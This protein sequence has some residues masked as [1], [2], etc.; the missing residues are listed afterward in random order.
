MDSDQMVNTELVDTIVREVKSQG[1]FDQFRK[2]CLADVD[3]KPAYQNLRQRVESAVTTF[4]EQQEWRPDANRIQMRE[5]LRKNIIGLGFLETGVDRIVDQVVNPKISSVFMPQIEDVVYKYLGIEKPIAKPKEE[6]TFEQNG[7]KNFDL[8][9][10]D[11]LEAVSPDSSKSA[12]S[13]YS[14]HED[15]KEEITEEEIVPELDESNDRIDDE[16]SPPFEPLEGQHPEDEVKKEEGED[17][18]QNSHVS[19]ISGLTSQDSLC[20]AKNPT[21]PMEVDEEVKTEEEEEGGGGGVVQDEQQQEEEIM[22][23]PRIDQMIEKS[24]V[25]E[26]TVSEVVEAME[27]GNQDSQ[28]SQVS[29]NSRLSIV[30]NESDSKD[31]NLKMDISE[32]AQM[33][34]FGENSQS[35]RAE[36]LTTF[37]IK[38]DEIKFQQVRIFPPPPEPENPPPL[39]PS[40]PPPLEEKPKPPAP[41]ESE[42]ETK[43]SDEVQKEA[44]NAEKVPEKDA[45]QKH[46][47]SD[48]K[49]SN[50]KS[51][52]SSH[53]NHHHHRD[54]NREKSR[55]SSSREKSTKASETSPKGGGGSV[56]EEDNSSTA[57]DSDASPV[58]HIVEGETLDGEPQSSAVE[59]S[60]GKT[61]SSSSHKSS[62]SSHRDDKKKSHSSH[63]KDSHRRDHRRHHDKHKSSS[64]QK[65][66]SSRSE[67]TK[68]KEEGS[69]SSKRKEKESDDHSS[70]REKTSE[71]RRSTDRD[72]NDGG[73]SSGSKQATPPSS[74]KTT[75]AANQSSAPAEESANNSANS[76]VSNSPQDK[77]TV[78]SESAAPPADAANANP[79]AESA[80]KVILPS[81]PII[82]DQILTAN[83]E[84]NLQMIVNQAS[85]D[86]TLAKIE[87]L[88]KKSLARKKPKFASNFKEAKRLMKMRKKIDHESKKNM[89]KAIVLAKNYINSKAESDP[90][91]SD[92]SQGIE[93]EFVCMKSSGNSAAP[94][95]SSP[96]K[97]DTP[98]PQVVATSVPEKPILEGKCSKDNFADSE[99]EEEL[100]YFPDPHCKFTESITGK[101]LRENRDSI[102]A[103]DDKE[104]FSH[105]EKSKKSPKNGIV[106]SS[107]VKKKSL[108]LG[109]AH[110][111][112]KRIRMAPNK[113]GDL[114]GNEDVIE[115]KKVVKVKTPLTQQQRYS[116]DDLY[117]PRPF[118]HG[119]RT[120]RR[121]LD[122]SDGGTA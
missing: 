112:E 15:I 40:P 11:L 96:I 87:E 69:S 95:I 42:A 61:K 58:L 54:R 28:L 102:L 13:M 72:S 18:S 65:S 24:E 26:R 116:S 1:L 4:L 39:P 29:S 5:K 104:I 78:K 64:S 38:K 56:R 55:S 75:T 85:N 121:A 98:P 106:A 6:P 111:E 73:G 16:E 59:K 113:F 101:W 43:G 35:P 62:S 25:P 57:L 14:S 68:S 70:Q 71:K 37:D 36:K 90:S 21:E 10:T 108:E 110:P 105:E 8:L 117:K 81:K 47:S 53:H 94:T 3:T 66:S 122:A 20:S 9:P 33:P 49:K 7:M 100:H 48:R 46:H 86:P 44:P 118:I 83:S 60:D 30:T 32:E 120:R 115:E 91:V 22:Q 67:R 19:G 103:G 88:A 84:I 76:S 79:S 89:E 80:E 107:I 114:N 50:K 97:K 77:E 52:R 34:E 109:D 82:V 99:D 45:A 17:D 93:L 31:D 23:P 41:P 92:L 12:K 2:E 63:S 51:S 74:D 119:Q 27:V